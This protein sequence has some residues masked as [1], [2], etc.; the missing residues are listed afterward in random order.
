MLTIAYIQHLAT[1]YVG[2]ADGSI[3]AYKDTISL[4]FIDDDC[5]NNCLTSLDPIMTYHDIHQT[6]VTL[7]P[8]VITTSEETK[9]EL[10]IG[11]TKREITIL[12]AR[13]LSVVD[14]V[15]SD[16]DQTPTPRCLTDLSFAYL[17]ANDGMSVGS[18][19]GSS[20]CSG[21]ESVLVY[22]ALQH[23][24]Y[25]SCWDAVSKELVMCVNLKESVPQCKLGLGSP[26]NF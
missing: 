20:E 21:T 5:N 23:G 19:E 26:A 1:V 6:S 17:T 22:G 3:K 18:I 9:Y 15:D 13:N 4:T 14:F 11:Q 24:Q 2:L 12:D 8:V 10:W 16:A 7:L 25:I